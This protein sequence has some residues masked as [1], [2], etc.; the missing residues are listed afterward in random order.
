MMRRIWGRS[1]HARRRF[2]PT[3]DVFMRVDL[4]PILSGAII[5]VSM[6]AAP[7]EAQQPP[8]GN[9][10]ATTILATS[11]TLTWTA[12]AGA[13]G[14]VVQRALGQNPLQRLTPDKITETAY[15][16]AAAPAASALRYR[17]KAFF[18]GGATSL[19]SILNV[20][21]PSAPSNTASGNQPS[22]QPPGQPTT[23]PATIGAVVGAT[24]RAGATPLRVYTPTGT[25]GITLEAV[26][27]TAGSAPAPTTPTA[28]DPG[29]FSASLQGDKV[30]L[31]WQAVPGISWYLL[32]GP[33][34]GQSGQRVQGT[35]YTFNSPGPGQHEWTVAS[36]GGQ[37]Q[38]PVNNWVNW[39]KATLSIESKTGNYRI[40]VTGIRAEHATRD[41]WW[42]R[43]GK[44]DEVY[45][46][47]FVQVFDRS[48]G[49]LLSSRTI[50]SPIHGDINGF[51][52]G[53]RVRAGTASDLGGIEDG[54]QVSPVL[55]QP[56][57][58]AQ[59]YPL[60]ALWQGTLTSDREVVVIHPV[61]WE[62]DV[63]GDNDFS[64]NTWRQ[65]LQ[66]NPMRDW[67]V[68]SVQHPDPQALSWF[69]EEPPV[70]LWGPTVFDMGLEDNIRDR[71]IGLERTTNGF[72]SGD[73]CGYWRDHLL[74]VTRE[75][76]ER[77][78]TSSSSP[79]RG[80]LELELMDYVPTDDGR[81]IFWTALNGSYTVYLKVERA[82]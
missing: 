52:A 70:P 27:P 63:G 53:S 55:G 56:A 41:D 6:W 7:L 30:T 73:H 59:G 37:E 9:L 4:Q 24:G 61:L 69:Q 68:P 48:S 60:L 78:L 16:D 19:S 42:S 5:W 67:A 51:P 18:V 58:G 2:R 77:E 39:P 21:T 40:M 47:A 3:G 66:N 29:G 72:C 10:Q 26:Q 79:D 36:L 43:D 64:Y 8:P 1:P 25:R 28:A 81:R 76:I 12:P 20:T 74:V 35:S 82:P 38:G 71:P 75:R 49:Q 80:V 34:M 45:V 54:D 44:W 32:G 46:S 33:A 14:Y 17:V 31:S 23:E 11:V 65:F 57:P 50:K 13:T 62:A 22:G 15:T